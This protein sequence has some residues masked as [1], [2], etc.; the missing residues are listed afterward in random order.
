MELGAWAIEQVCWGEWIRSYES[1]HPYQKLRKYSSVHALTLH[2]YFFLW[3]KSFCVAN[4]SIYSVDA[5]SVSV[6]LN[7]ARMLDTC[8]PLEVVKQL[9]CVRREAVFGP[10]RLVRSRLVSAYSLSQNT[11]QS[12]KTI[13][14]LLLNSPSE[15]RFPKYY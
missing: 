1:I 9:K 15:H 14:N 5:K 13:Q 6:I 10:V 2:A 12:S 7:K 11:I 3:G 8:I 4:H